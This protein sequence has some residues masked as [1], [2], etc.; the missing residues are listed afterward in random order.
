MKVQFSSLSYL[1]NWKTRFVYFILIPMIN[2]CLLVL[3][4]AQYTNTFNWS[5]AIATTTLSG[6][7]LAMSSISQLFVMDRTLKIDRELVVN[8]P[9]SVRYWGD[10]VLTS[11]LAGLVLIITNLIILGILQAP[12]S[13]L[14][15]SIAMAPLIIISGII[16]GFLA[17]IAAWKMNNPY[18][19]M[20]LIGALTTIVAGT[21]VLVEKYP[22]WLR[23]VS[24]FF[25]FSQTI[26]Y[27]VTGH[28]LIY[29]DLIVDMIWLICGVICY[30]VQ[31]KKILK[32]PEQIF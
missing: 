4:N 27:V 19:Y 2:L 3:I 18:F 22:Q 26:H 12:I 32:A 28:G 5:V 29:W 9:F 11:A 21:L 23:I 16:V 1:Q 25:P 13:L 7:S 8:R 6:G 14:F 30:R 10:K 31:I 20:N 17:A 15:R 24:Y